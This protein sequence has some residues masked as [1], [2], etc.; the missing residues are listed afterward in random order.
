MTQRETKLSESLLLISYKE[1]TTFCRKIWDGGFKNRILRYQRAIGFAQVIAI[2]L[3]T[4]DFSS[5]NHFDSCPNFASSRSSSSSETMTQETL[6]LW[7]TAVFNETMLRAF[8]LIMFKVRRGTALAAESGY[9][10][11]VVTSWQ[12]PQLHL[13]PDLYRHGNV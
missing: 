6:C 8:A 9:R 4:S 10:F 3:L 2:L 7:S 11:T 1:S 5:H 12:T 13:K